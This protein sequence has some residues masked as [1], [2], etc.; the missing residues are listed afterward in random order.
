MASWIAA[1]IRRH[2]VGVR[3]PRVGVGL[4]VPS[5]YNALRSS[6]ERSGFCAAEDRGMEIAR[7]LESI[8][9]ARK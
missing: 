8:A 6:R 1:E 4:G 7:D 9:L 5:E 2:T 3:P